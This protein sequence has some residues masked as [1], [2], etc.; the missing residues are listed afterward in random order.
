M[1]N[2]V[3]GQELTF[4]FTK[5]GAQALPNILPWTSGYVPVVQ[6]LVPFEY[7]LFA[8]DRTA[9]NP[10]PFRL[11]VLVD[12]APYAIVTPQ[13][14][15]ATVTIQTAGLTEG[16]HALR[17]T[18]LDIPA[19]NNLYN[20]V[21]LMLIVDND[22]QARVDAQDIWY[23]EQGSKWQRVGYGQTVNIPQKVRYTPAAPA[24]TGHPQRVV[25]GTPYTTNL[26]GTALYV[27]NV[28]P[29]LGLYERVPRF[30]SLP[31]GHII[32]L[33]MNTQ[34]ADEATDA[35]YHVDTF[36]LS[37]GPRNTAYVS[38]YSVGYVCWASEELHFIEASYS[39]G[40]F[41]EIELDGTVRTLAGWRMKPG[42]VPLKPDPYP[43]DQ[44]Y[45]LGTQRTQSYAAQQELVGT[46]VD[47]IAGFRT[48]SDL[49]Q[50]PIRP[51]VTY[52]ADSGY[53]CIRK[54]DHS[55]SPA[56]V[57]VFAGSLTGQ[58]GLVDGQGT[59]ARFSTPHSLA[60]HSDGTLYVADR[61]NNRLRKIDPSGNVTTVI[62]QGFTVNEGGLV[63]LAPDA[64]RP[65]YMVNGPVATASMVHPFCIRCDSRGRVLVWEDYI[66]AIRRYD[67]VAGTIEQLIVPPQRNSAWGWFDVAR[68]GQTGPIDDIYFV[69]GTHGQGV[70]GPLN[71]Q[72]FH[73]TADGGAVSGYFQ[74]SGLH[75]CHLSNRAAAHY[76]WLIAVGRGAIW[77]NGYGSDGMLRVRQA[78]AGDPPVAGEY[79]KNRYA[80]LAGQAVH[81]GGTVPGFPFGRPTFKNLRGEYGWQL[82][83]LSCFDDIAGLPDTEL[84][85]LIQAGMGTGI[86]RPE[87]TGRHLDGYRSFIKAYAT[88][89]VKANWQQ[90][91]TVASTVPVISG[92]AFAH[93]GS[94]ST[95]TWT[96]DQPC[97]GFVD[98]GSVA[99][100]RYRSEG[101]EGAHT[102]T[103]AM[104]ISNLTI[105]RTY[106][107]TIGAKN[108]AGDVVMAT[109]N[110][111]AQ[112][113]TVAQ[114]LHVTQG[115]AI[116]A[117][118]GW[119][120]IDDASIRGLKP[121]EPGGSSIQGHEGQSGVIED[122][123]GAAW[124]TRR[125]RL[126]LTGG[127]HQGYYGNEVYAW[128]A[129]THGMLRLTNPGRPPAG[130][131][132]TLTEAVMDGTQPSARH[133]YN[134]SC[135]IPTLDALLLFGGAPSGPG[136]FSNAIWLYFCATGQW[137]RQYTLGSVPAATDGQHALYD[138]WTDTVILSDRVALYRYDWRSA[139]IVTLRGLQVQPHTTSIIDLETRGIVFLGD[140]E[141]FR[142]SLSPDTPY[143]G[144]GVSFAT[145]TWSGSNFNYFPGMAYDKKRKQCVAWAGGDG[146]LIL[147]AGGGGWRAVDV[148]GSPGAQ[149]QNGTYRRL[150]YSAFLDAYVL[151][152][153]Y[154][155]D[156]YIL[157]LP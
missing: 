27:E 155:Q 13:G 86:A 125:E 57:T 148:A 50:D 101:I 79:E 25:Q 132:L 133:T 21:P 141:S 139:T 150:A 156:M 111:L 103:H 73:I 29:G 1:S 55:A 53:H 140:Y 28:L 90:P 91:A 9:A 8:P 97:L 137:E 40:R 12:E 46:W 152:N 115:S 154:S 117:D 153:S 76:P 80:R 42:V 82:W 157:R 62:G 151:Q 75:E 70:W 142:I 61:G 20:S 147:P 5:A 35:Q 143:F 4:M 16:S 99:G 65:T 47:G 39:R 43:D 149:A 67:P 32:G 17:L 10:G 59:A 48:P 56:V 126:L 121:H 145:P 131:F 106:F 52:I 85:A 49:A 24:L 63:H 22:G 124:D 92:I 94:G 2:N 19:G 87:I 71:E 93:H 104:D 123:A 36:P 95:V 114:P 107:Y 31:G 100:Q 37:D 88:G 146:V 130:G 41:A 77:M 26:P 7:G 45:L 112:T 3:N 30:H 81:Y 135:Y 118:A 38:S 64:N 58:A 119:Y 51:D 74:G 128:E 113:V 66:G 109:G 11:Q 134:G 83:G 69:Q 72:L 129:K 44:T 122:W 116:P 144:V 89:T 84:N 68:D 136:G 33:S 127:G 15:P 96:T 78:V 23:A 98:L 6:G 60:M 120:V 108:L 14:F 34:R 102:L 54:V 110:F 18:L 105:G 138:P